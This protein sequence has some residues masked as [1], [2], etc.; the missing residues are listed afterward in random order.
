M[1]ELFKTRGRCRE[2]IKVQ[3][4]R[5]K[6]WSTDRHGDDETSWIFKYSIKSLLGGS[7]CRFSLADCVFYFLAGRRSSV[8]ISPQWSLHPMQRSA[9]GK[10][11]SHFTF[12]AC[13]FVDSSKSYAL[14]Q[15]HWTSHDLKWNP[16]YF[17]ASCNCTG[18]P[19]K[20]HG[21]ISRVCRL[22]MRWLVF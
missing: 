9:S 3:T 7:V 5:S 6:H 22:K 2:V 18:T 11:S 17:G 19:F 1:F 20:L 4:S 21:V 15:S 14:D 12:K 16:F 8:P 10:S 13:A